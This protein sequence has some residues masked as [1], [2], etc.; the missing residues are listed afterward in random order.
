MYKAVKVIRVYPEILRN[1]LQGN[2]L[3]PGRGL[4]TQGLQEGLLLFGIF[5][6]CVR[7]Q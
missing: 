6:G 5:V 3:E 7:M 2:V 4:V 1:L